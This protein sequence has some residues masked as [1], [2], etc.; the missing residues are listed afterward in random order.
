MEELR[1]MARVVER[2]LGRP[3]D[4]TLLILDATTG[5]NAI[6]QAR[7]FLSAVSVTGIVLAKLDGTAKGG[8]VITIKDEFGVPIKLVGAGESLDD[9]EE[10]DPREFVQALIESSPNAV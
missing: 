6:N 8:I 2:A 3:V 1:K 9:L 5:Q 10:F 4:E 7:E